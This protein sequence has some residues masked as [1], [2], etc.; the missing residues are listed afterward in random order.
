M[1]AEPE[2]PGRQPAPAPRGP[3]AEDPANQA[4]IWFVGRPIG[5]LV[6]GSR[7][8]AGSGDATAASPQDGQPAEPGSPES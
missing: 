1:P 3:A 2:Q 4:V 6:R 8:A 5:P 7:P